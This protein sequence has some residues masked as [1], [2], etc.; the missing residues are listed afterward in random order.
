MTGCVK[1]LLLEFITQQEPGLSNLDWAA[2]HKAT[3][4]LLTEA[5]AARRE[6]EEATRAEEE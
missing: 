3:Y 4:A 5:R 1:R 6:A 2:I